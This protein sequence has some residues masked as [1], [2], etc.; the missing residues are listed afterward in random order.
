M[1]HD[2]GVV[3]RNGKLSAAGVQFPLA[4]GESGWRA[5]AGTGL[6]APGG[7]GVVA[8]DRCADRGGVGGNRDDFR[9][10]EG[11]AGAEPDR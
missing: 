5:V 2:M 7:A 3:V 9:G 4:E 10:G 1:L 11:P 8:G 6:A